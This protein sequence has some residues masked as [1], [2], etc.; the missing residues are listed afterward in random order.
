MITDKKTPVTPGGWVRL[1]LY[2]IAVF[3]GLAAV[4]AEPLGFAGLTEVLMSISGVL[5]VA[6]GGTAALNL[7]KADDQKLNVRQLGPAVID[8]VREVQDLR[9]QAATP[10]DVANELEARHLAVPAPAG[11]RGGFSAYHDPQTS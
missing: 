7:G 1:G 5:L 8:L 10:E 4:L 11:D 6:T 2:V 9:R 3:T